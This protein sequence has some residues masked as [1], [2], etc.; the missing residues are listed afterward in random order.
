MTPSRGE[1]EGLR[2]VHWRPG[3]GGSAAMAHTLAECVGCFIAVH[4]LV[5]AVL[6]WSPDTNPKQFFKY[7][8]FYEYAN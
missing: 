3:G 5:V 6:G 7:G 4:V 1:D 8:K 2:E